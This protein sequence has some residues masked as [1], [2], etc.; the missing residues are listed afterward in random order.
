VIPIDASQAELSR[1]LWTPDA[2]AGR[3]IRRKSNRELLQEQCYLNT[4]YN[5]LVMLC[6]RLQGNLLKSHP[7]KFE[8]FYDVFITQREEIMMERILENL[9]KNNEINKK[10]NMMVLIGNYHFDSIYNFLTLS[11]SSSS[12]E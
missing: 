4:K 2:D 1:L 6:L 11:S 12:A 8:E 3:N 7:R 9:K 10:Q 5:F